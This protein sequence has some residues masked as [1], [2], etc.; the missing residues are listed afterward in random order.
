MADC[1]WAKGQTL[2]RQAPLLKCG[3]KTLCSLWA[4][5]QP[6]ARVTCLPGNLLLLLI[7]L[8][9][10]LRAFPQYVTQT[11]LPCSGSI[12]GESHISLTHLKLTKLLNLYDKI[13]NIHEVTRVRTND[14]RI[15]HVIW[16]KT[17][18]KL[19]IISLLEKLNKYRIEILAFPYKERGKM[20]S[21][22]TNI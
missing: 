2:R 19:K 8:L 15:K 11:N 9:P 20:F 21:E 13:F 7:S 12:S 3:S 22:T 14:D 5:E 6:P 16:Q 1:C 4:P 10:F 18:Q 17:S